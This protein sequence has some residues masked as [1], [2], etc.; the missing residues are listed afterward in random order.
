MLRDRGPNGDHATELMLLKDVNSI[1]IPTQL[2][3]KLITSHTHCNPDNNKE[4]LRRKSF[5]CFTFTSKLTSTR[6]ELKGMWITNIWKIVSHIKVWELCSILCLW[7][8]SLFLV[9][10]N[11]G[12]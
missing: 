4:R 7:F 3:P 11:K 9:I 6:S 8:L 5:S 12:S 10:L 2:S 1:C